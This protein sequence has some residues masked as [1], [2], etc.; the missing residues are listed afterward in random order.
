MTARWSKTPPT[1][2]GWYWCRLPAP[3]SR[4]DALR[5]Y[6]DE[7]RAWK[8]ADGDCC[9]RDSL[10]DSYDACLWCRIDDPPPWEG[11]GV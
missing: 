6:E 10:L 5:V 2:P 3:D 11:G 7:S 1:V 8:V 4:V 9:N